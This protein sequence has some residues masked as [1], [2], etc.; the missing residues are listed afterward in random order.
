MSHTLLAENIEIIDCLHVS[1]NRRSY[2]S[3]NSNS[4]AYDAIYPIKEYYHIV[5]M[6]F[7]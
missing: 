2:E 7:H 4:V 1:P 5:V 6:Q 3:P